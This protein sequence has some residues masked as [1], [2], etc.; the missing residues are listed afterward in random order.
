MFIENPKLKRFFCLDY[1][2]SGRSREKENAI[3]ADAMASHVT[4]SHLIVNAGKCVCLL[5]ED[6]L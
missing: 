1:H 3:A 5:Y 4:S 2:Y 6:H